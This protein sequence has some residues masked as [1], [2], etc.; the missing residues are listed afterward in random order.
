MD[1]A[2]GPGLPQIRRGHGEPP[3][4]TTPSPG[5]LELDETQLREI[6]E[7]WDALDDEEPRPTLPV[8]PG[9]GLDPQAAGA[10][11]ALGHLT[12]PSQLPYLSSPDVHPDVHD[13]LN[14][15]RPDEPT[16]ATHF[17]PWHLP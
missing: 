9:T 4:P 6:G 8:V 7:L 13:I 2:T 17:D 15:L 14:L 3:L 12:D 5:L 16:E 1:T 10:A 11:Q